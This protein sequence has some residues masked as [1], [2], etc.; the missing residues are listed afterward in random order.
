M[1]H[2]RGTAAGLRD[3]TH[4][5]LH[6]ERDVARDLAE[7]RD[8]DT[9][10]GDERGQAIAVRMPRRL[11]IAQAELGSERRHLRAAIAEGRE[12]TRGAA[13]LQH[14]SVGGSSVDAPPAA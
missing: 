10:R 5:V 4:L 12:R 11:R 6:Q 2:R 8:V 9:A 7:R 3:L 1:R 13:E 14:C